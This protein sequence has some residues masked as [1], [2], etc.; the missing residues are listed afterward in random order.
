MALVQYNDSRPESAIGK[1]SNEKTIK[2]MMKNL[3]LAI[4]AAGLMAGCSSEPSKP[5]T[6]EKPQPKAPPQAITGSTAFFKCYISA[7]GWAPAAQP[8]RVEPPPGP[9]SNSRAGRAAPATVERFWGWKSRPCG[10]IANRTKHWLGS[11]LGE[12]MRTCFRATWWVEA[13][14]N[15]A[16][17]GRTSLAQRFSAGKRRRHMIQVPEGRPK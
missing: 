14:E 13:Q 2:L 8:Y 15:P 11:I 9:D 7:R 6:A 5:A 1:L 12:C 16:P 17:E 4:L 10:S 3:L